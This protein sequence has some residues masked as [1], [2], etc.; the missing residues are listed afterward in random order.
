MPADSTQLEPK[1][2]KR[3]QKSSSKKEKEEKKK[4]SV[5]KRS[6]HS[7]DSSNSSSDSDNESDL[8]LEKELKPIGGYVK[9]REEMCNQMFKCIGIKKL[10]S[11]L[12]EILMPFSAEELQKM[13][14]EQLDGMS[15]KRIL[16]IIDG[17]DPEAISSSGT[18]EEA[19]ESMDEEI[20][21]A[22]DAAPENKEN[23]LQLDNDELLTDEEVFSVQPNKE[24]SRSPCS[25]DYS[26]RS[27][28]SSRS[29]DRSR[30]PLQQDEQN[31]IRSV[32]ISAPV[33]SDEECHSDDNSDAEDKDD[34]LAMS[35]S[36][37]GEILECRREDME[38]MQEEASALRRKEDLEKN[39][40]PVSDAPN[41]NQA[42]PI[43]TAAVG[44]DEETSVQT[45]NSVNDA[46]PE[47]S[48][49]QMEILE[50]EMRARAIKAMLEKRK[51]AAL[52]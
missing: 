11:M 21:Q 16:R 1:I 28:L 10:R 39:V 3:R 9:N 24:L 14:L 36:E 23:M 30:S 13:C 8:D 12:P 49:T 20:L 42:E 50:L 25:S 27:R 41:V 29:S 2:Q 37:D 35:G 33:L 22:Q 6:H 5:K 44:S 45:G 19:E 15:K 38:A 7:N 17:A 34:L 43:D 31:D 18:E 46:N 47:L 40:V 48:S 51:A 26:N 52:S 4:K 32:E